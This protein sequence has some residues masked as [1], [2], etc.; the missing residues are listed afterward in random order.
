VAGD[1]G[2]GLWARE[3]ARRALGLACGKDEEDA[4]RVAAAV[5]IVRR[6][7]RTR[8]LFTPTP[9]GDMPPVKPCLSETPAPRAPTPPPPAPEL[10]AQTPPVHYVPP[11]PDPDV[12]AAARAAAIARQGYKGWSCAFCGKRE[13]V[14]GKPNGLRRR[15]PGGPK[16]LCNACGVKWTRKETVKRERREW[17]PETPFHPHKIAKQKARRL[18]DRSRSHKRRV[19]NPLC[20]KGVEL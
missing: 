11:A 5:N 20:H 3:D 13:P 18:K 7:A 8:T 4:S 1:P 10:R 2:L 9:D 12:V 14:P 6:T 17:T 15:G 19:D 16:T